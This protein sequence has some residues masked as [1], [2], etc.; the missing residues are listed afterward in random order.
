MEE[1]GMRSGGLVDTAFLPGIMKKFWGWAILM[2]AQPCEYTY[3]QR[4]AHLSVVK[5][6]SFMHILPPIKEKEK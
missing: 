3:C 6:V 2:I 4:A 5:M 1:W